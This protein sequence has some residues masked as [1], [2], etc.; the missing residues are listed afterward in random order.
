MLV[1]GAAVQTA[2]LVR[3]QTRS[4]PATATWNVTGSAPQTGS[5]AY[6]SGRA[7]KAQDAEQGATAPASQAK[8]ITQSVPPAEQSAKAA[9]PP[10]PKI[11]IVID[12][13]T[14]EMKVFVDDVER[15]RWKVSTGIR[16][17]DTRNL[18]S[19]FHE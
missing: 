6:T 17:Y 2:P 11:L 18:H 10:S 14:Q 19:P 5:S 7:F 1:F 4:D 12:K 15:Y 3:A 16:R 8:P 9:K 13:P